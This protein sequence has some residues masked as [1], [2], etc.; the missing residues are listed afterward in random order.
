MNEYPFDARLLLT[1]RFPATV[2]EINFGRYSLR[3]I[4]TRS[5]VMGEAILSFRNTY[6]APKGGGS[7]PEDEARM[8]SNLISLCCNVRVKHEGIR[9]NEI[10]IP[11]PEGHESQAYPQFFGELDTSKLERCLTRI[12]ALNDDLARQCFRACKTYSFA[13]ENIPSDPTFAFFLLIV[14]V[15]CFSSQEAVISSEELHKDSMKCERFCR[16]IK[17]HLPAQLRG[18][19]ENDEELFTSL[20]KTAYYSH[21]SGFAHGGKEVSDAARQADRAGSSYF[22]HYVDGKEV[23]T[24][25]IGWFAK[26][27]QGSVLGFIE[28]QTDSCPDEERIP[29]L[30][31]EKSG[32]TVKYNK[33]MKKGQVVTFGDIDYR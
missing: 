32:L 26:I 15:E 30:A 7:H 9:I 17:E 19:D 23:R 24:P 1:K 33:D 22:K 12:Q 25:G 5:A 28:K 13:L 18:D 31:Y 16:F 3:V 29:R 14:T 2:K 11:H 8:V 10:D 21:R 4:P 6:G 27:V 20:L